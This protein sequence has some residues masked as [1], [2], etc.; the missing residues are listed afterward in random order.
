MRNGPIT[1]FFRSEKAGL[2]VEFVAVIGPFLLISFFIME[3]LVAM[4][5]VGTAEKAAQLGAR[6]AVV[7]TP[8]VTTG[9]CPVAGG[10]IGA[11]LLPLVNCKPVAGAFG[12]PCPGN[13]A[14]WTTNPISCAGGSG[15]SCVAANFTTIVNRMIGISPLLKQGC[16]QASPGCHVTITY[17]NSNLGFAGGPTIPD[18]TVK[19]SGVPYGAV[20]T[21]I[22]GKFFGAN[23]VLTV[24]PDISVT[25]TG[26]DLNSLGS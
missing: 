7:S 17:A 12:Q 14:G 15:G 9:A 19:I 13:C 2:T 26:E 6:L 4:D 25:L 5:W 1:R 24:L 18:V 10:S 16:A 21:T 23:N 8:A 3:V 11:G 22:I 20:M